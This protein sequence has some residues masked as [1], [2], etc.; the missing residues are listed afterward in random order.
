M[1][2]EGF[3]AD[4]N[5]LVL[6]DRN[7]EPKG[8][9]PRLHTGLGVFWSFLGSA[10]VCLAPVVANV[11]VAF[12]FTLV[13]QTGRQR[14]RA[15]ALLVALAT[16]AAMTGAL[17]GVQG[18]PTT[19]LSVLCSYVLSRQLVL[20]KLHTGGLL[21]VT[22]ATTLIMMG[23]DIVST[24]LQGTTVTKVITSLVDQAVEAN[25][26]QVDLDGTSA[27]LE[28]RDM[29]VAYWP[30][31]YFLVSAGMA[32]FALLGA[33][34]GERSGGNSQHA[35]I[36]TRYDVPVWVAGLFAAGV[37]FEM[38]GPHL[39]AWKDEVVLL[40]ANL[41]MTM[42]LVL[43][44]QGISVLLWWLSE[45]HAAW[46]TRVLAV[47]VSLWFEASF[48]LTSVAGLVDVAVNFR[49]LKRRRPDLVPRPAR[50]G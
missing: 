4:S 12:G 19:L 34:L 11:L 27:L 20:G 15:I 14:D 39:P 17:M 2:P 1:V 36:A 38:L 13:M 40:G 8:G 46:A 5:Q 33:L 35:G 28:T 45:R 43:A 41:V 7:E 30:T 50:E 25:L 21:V 47:L 22:L 32:L 10:F 9:S 44:L 37:A 42:R 31:M 16:G 3:D 48:A 23:A 6:W 26:S 49:R 18:M 29:L 24:S